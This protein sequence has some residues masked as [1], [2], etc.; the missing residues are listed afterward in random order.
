MGIKIR[1]YV[2]E[3][4]MDEYR[5][6]YGFARIKEIIEHC[7]L[8][9][10]NAPWVCGICRKEF[11]KTVFYVGDGKFTKFCTVC[12]EIHVYQKTERYSDVIKDI[13]KFHRKQL[14]LHKHQIDTRLT[15]SK[16]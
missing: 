10:S 6:G 14:R 11:S 9:V 1:R 8:H 4:E 13:V 2:G 3:N 16:L 12:A 5:M 7:E 15:S